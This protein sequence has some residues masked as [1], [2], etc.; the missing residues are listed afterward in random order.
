MCLST[1]YNKTNE[2]KN[3]L[4]RNIMDVQLKDGNLVFTDIL[5]VQTVL[6]GTI[7][8]INLTDNYILVSKAEA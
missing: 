4:C 6:R 8:K 5:G 3:L 2:Q 1:V 7:D